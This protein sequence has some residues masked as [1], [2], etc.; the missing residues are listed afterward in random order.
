MR[1]G[2][3]GAT[4]TQSQAASNLAWRELRDLELERAAA[5][6][7]IGR[8]RAAP[9]RRCPRRLLEAQR[10]RREAAGRLLPSSLPAAAASPASRSLKLRARGGGRPGDVTLQL[11]ALREGRARRR[12]GG[13]RHVRLLREEGARRGE[14]VDG[15]LHVGRVARCGGRRRALDGSAVSLLPL[16]E[17]R[18]LQRRDLEPLDYARAARD[19]EMHVV[20]QPTLPNERRVLLVP[21]VLE[22]VRQPLEAVV[23][24]VLE[25][26]D[27]PK[28][29]YARRE[30]R[31]GRVARKGRRCSRAGV[32]GSEQRTANSGQRAARLQM[33]LVVARR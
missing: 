33:R 5:A 20:R 23:V 14:P 13:A 4:G 29:G 32:V 17:H 10:A 11:A 31:L 16:D 21:P 28:E 12:A 24:P 7:G 6:L 8:P 3:R 1:G 25:E 9:R 18:L 27:A 2:R 15:G 26:K 19:E 22:R 30:V